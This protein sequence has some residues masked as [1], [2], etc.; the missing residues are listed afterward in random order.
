MTVPWVV[1]ALPCTASFGTF[2]CFH[3]Q[4]RWDK[5]DIADSEAYAK[6]NAKTITV[7]GGGGAGEAKSAF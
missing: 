7:C 2:L 5:P 1:A 4:Q 3:D 6:E